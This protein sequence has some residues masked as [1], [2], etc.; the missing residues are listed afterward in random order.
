MSDDLFTSVLD[1]RSFSARKAILRFRSY[2]THKGVPVEIR[3]IEI[4]DPNFKQADI[5]HLIDEEIDYFDEK[6]G[7]V[8]IAFGFPPHTFELRGTQI[9]IEKV[10]PDEIDFRR[11][12]E[13]NLETAQ[14]SEAR[15]LAASNKLKSAER[16]INEELKR[17]HIKSDLSDQHAHAE[18]K[19]ISVLNRVLNKL[20]D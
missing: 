19:A 13:R 18:A 4:I 15:R 16:F 6:D 9:S 8:S 1:R 11:I 2:A 20:A 14:S 7:G 17:A 3:Q 12:I 5:D 10:A